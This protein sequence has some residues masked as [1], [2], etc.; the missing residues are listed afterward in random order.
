MMVQYADFCKEM[1]DIEKEKGNRLSNV[2][3]CRPL[4]NLFGGE[5]KGADFRKKMNQ[6]AT[7][8]EYQQNIKQ[9]ILDEIETYR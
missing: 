5:W 7:K 6:N 4:I 3:L 1:Q 9:L 2:H 8:P